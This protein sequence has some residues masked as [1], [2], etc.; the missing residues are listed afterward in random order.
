MIR[1]RETDADDAIRSAIHYLDPDL[2]DKRSATAVILIA[3]LVGLLIG[4]IVILL[5]LRGL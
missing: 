4:E 2:E 1:N 3:L 5:K